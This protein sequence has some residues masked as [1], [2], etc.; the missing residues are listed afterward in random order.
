VVAP[1]PSRRPG[2]AVLAGTAVVVALIVVSL[3]RYP[4]TL[5][6]PAAPA[7][8]VVLGLL[9]ALYLGLG[10]WA[11]YRP[12]TGRA[13]GLLVGVVAGAAWSVEIWA[14]GPG[15]LSRSAESIV[16][17]T[18]ALLAVAVSVAAGP[19]A[20]VRGRDPGAA[21]RAGVFAGLA[22]GIVTFGCGVVMTLSSLDAL[23]TR[24][25]YQREF[26]VSSSP[27]IATYLVNDILAATTAHLAINLFLGVVGGG[28]G[29]LVARASGRPDAAA[30]VA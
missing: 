16:G 25:D 10:G 28:I 5:D 1:V 11:A 27:D 15:M 29:A 8:L 6:D 7:Y 23:A 24:A 17:G 21:L 12:R 13:L 2:W 19:F 20:A 9:L 4:A 14:G 22:S 3:L 26:A 30:T 18:F